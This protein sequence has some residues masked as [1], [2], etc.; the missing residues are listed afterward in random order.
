MSY[1]TN[2]LYQKSVQ[3]S[4]SDSE[5]A[6][7]AA[8][9]QINILG[10]KATDTGCSISANTGGYTIE[11]SGIY[12]I[13]YD[14]TSTP[15]AAGDQIL[16]LYKDGVALPSA[17]STSATTEGGVLTQ[18]VEAVLAIRTCSAVTPSITAR[19]SGVAGTINHT[20]ASAVKL[21]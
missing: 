5:Q 12:R 14:V 4:Y 11:S 1:C 9:S 16:Q 10:T 19:I 18:H 7:V 20:R 2:R 21:A 13:S 3:E 6:Y 8:G 17:I 15:S